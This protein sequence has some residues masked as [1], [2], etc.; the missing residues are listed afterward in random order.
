[1]VRRAAQWELMQTAVNVM[2]PLRLQIAGALSIGLWL[3]VLTCGRMLA[4]LD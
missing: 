2:P 1:L 4:F 3:A